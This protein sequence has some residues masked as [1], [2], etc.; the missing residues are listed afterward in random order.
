MSEIIINM[1]ND[2]ILKLKNVGFTTTNRNL[3]SV[4]TQVSVKETIL[5]RNNE[6]YVTTPQ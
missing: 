4:Y 3:M 5:G 2:N 1:E 6:E